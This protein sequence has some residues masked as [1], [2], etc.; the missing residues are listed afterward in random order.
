[1]TFADAV[2]TCLTKKYY[3]FSGRATRPEFWKFI[4]FMFLGM[5]VCLIINSVLFGPELEYRQSLDTQGNPI[6]QPQPVI[7]YTSGIVGNIFGLGVL[8]PWLAVT[9]RRMHDSGRRGWLPFVPY[10]VTLLV[11]IAVVLSSLGPTATGT[12]LQTSGHA[13]VSVNGWLAAIMALLF[14]GTLILNTY[15]LTRPSDPKPNR[16]G[17]HPY[18]VTP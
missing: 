7:R 8:L 14:I 1:M 11:A 5:I 9:W 13:S 16:Y 4:L 17:P 10:L 6:G 15:W 18:E 3:T 2:T 12:Q